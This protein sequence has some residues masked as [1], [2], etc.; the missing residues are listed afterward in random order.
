MARKRRRKATTHRSPRRRA[1]RHSGYSFALAPVS[2][3]KRRRSG[4]RSRGAYH[5]N[6]VTGSAM[7]TA[8]LW[9]AEGAVN[10]LVSQTGARLPSS[11]MIVPLI[12]AYLSYKGHLKVDGMLPISI[13]EFLNQLKANSPSIQN[14]FNFGV[15]AVPASGYQIGAMGAAQPKTYAE[16]IRQISQMHSP[17]MNGMTLQARGLIPQR[18]GKR[19]YEF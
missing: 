16:T 15:N 19:V 8:I 5:V 17:Q 11:K 1:R 13:A 10:W 14:L 6:T 3:R 4:A 12:T 18:S 2:G 9:F 7:A